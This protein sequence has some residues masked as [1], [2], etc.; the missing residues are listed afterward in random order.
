VVVEGVEDLMTHMAQCCKPVPYDPVVGFVTRGR[1]VTVHRM[2]CINV[3]TMPEQEKARLIEVRWANQPVDAVYPVDLLIVAADRK[4]LLR[5]ISAVFSD[6]QIDVIG[7]NTVS[8]RTKDLAKMRFTM[9]VKDVSQVEHILV[10]L[11]QIPAVLDARRS[12]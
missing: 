11:G 3:R 6:E 10:K 5:D 7:V 4:G 8:D 1:G 9:E 12:H 2:D